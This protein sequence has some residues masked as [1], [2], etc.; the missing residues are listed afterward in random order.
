MALAAVAMTVSV[1]GCASRMF[2]EISGGRYAS[3][4]VGEA[5]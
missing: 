4:I 3:D 5:L 1:T 2:E